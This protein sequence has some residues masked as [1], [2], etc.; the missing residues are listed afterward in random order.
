M[1]EVTRGPYRRAVRGPWTDEATDHTRKLLLE[2]MP[3]S[4]AIEIVVSSESRHHAGVI[5]GP[6]TRHWI[7]GRGLVT[8]DR[9]RDHGEPVTEA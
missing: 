1:A 9:S 3:P 5:G 8:G 4:R 7:L 2:G 6:Q